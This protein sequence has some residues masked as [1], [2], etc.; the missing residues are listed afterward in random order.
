METKDLSPGARIAIGALLCAAGIA[1]GGYA[2][3][4]GSGLKPDRF[5]A[6]PIALSLVSAAALLAFPQASYTARSVFGALLITGFGV[7][8]SWIAFGPGERHFSVSI[9]FVGFAASGPASETPGRV[10]FGLIGIAMD[11]AALWSWW[12]LFKRLAGRE[13]SE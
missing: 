7:M 3:L 13:P 9:G 4:D 11:I 6:A 12:T 8:T 10:V 1:L 5:I 2:I